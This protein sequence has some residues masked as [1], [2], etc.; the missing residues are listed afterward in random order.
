M[1]RPRHFA[2]AL[3]VL[4]PSA[5]PARGDEAARQ[6]VREPIVDVQHCPRRNVRKPK[7]L[8]PGTVVPSRTK[9]LRVRREPERLKRLLDGNDDERR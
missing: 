4:L 9:S 3:A 7:G 1:P 2:L 6:R 8:P 5:I